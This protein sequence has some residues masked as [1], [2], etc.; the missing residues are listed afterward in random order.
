[1]R[2]EDMSLGALASLPDVAAGFPDQNYPLFSIF[3][4]Q[5]DTSLLT[6]SSNQPNTGIDDAH[7]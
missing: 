4:Y 6:N 3:L 2:K 1:M 5:I 7:F